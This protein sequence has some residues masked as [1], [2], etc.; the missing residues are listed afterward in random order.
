MAARGL[1]YWVNRWPP[2]GNRRRRSSGHIHWPSWARRCDGMVAVPLHGSR[3]L[4]LSTLPPAAAPD[5]SQLACA[6]NSKP[7]A[8]ARG[9]NGARAL[10]ALSPRELRVVQ[11]AAE[12]RTN[13]EIAYQLYVTL[14][15]IEGHLARAY[16]KLGIERRPQLSKFFAGKKPGYQPPSE[17]SSLAR[18]F[19]P[20]SIIRRRIQ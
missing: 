1:S 19:G 7:P 9:G 11:L 10:E 6:R 5:R 17:A 14:K 15:T 3:L 16:T 18:P 2:Y 8:H 12:G 4:R 13:R 20:Q